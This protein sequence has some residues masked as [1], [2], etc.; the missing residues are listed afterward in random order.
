MGKILIRWLINTS[1][2][3]LA[4]KFVPGITYSGSWWGILLVGVIF[5]LVN[6]FI[7]PFI[8]LFTLPLIILSLGL[9]TFVINAMMLSITSWLSGQFGMGFY[10][11][12]FR[13][14]FWGA[15]LIT[16]VSMV[17]SCL[18][19]NEEPEHRRI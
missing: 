6:A 19:P 5:G 15:L 17:L 1:A 10:V 7:R 13:S 2:I 11:Y 18:M 4:V 3:I 8:K 9:F 12:G 16:L 14:A